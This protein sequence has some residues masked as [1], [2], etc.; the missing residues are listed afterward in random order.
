MKI[1]II[2]TI[3][4][5]TVNMSLVSMYS[6]L[7]NNLEHEIEFYLVF[8]EKF[9]KQ[10]LSTFDELKNFSNLK[11][12]NPVKTESKEILHATSYTDYTGERLYLFLLG[13]LLPN[14]DK[15]LYISI[16][17]SR[18][19]GD[20]G[21][22]SAGIVDNIKTI[23]TSLCGALGLIAVML[24]SSWK[25]AFIGILVLCIAFIP[26]VLIRKRIKEASNKNM[27]IGSKITTNINE[28]Y[29]G[30]K[31]MAAYELQDRQNEYF[32]SQLYLD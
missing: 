10:N 15:I 2:Y 13:K 12:I 24:Y 25:L 26:V 32:K 4:N 21:T 23:T 18:Y 20:P 1:N 7:T 6:V 11:N 8:D 22:A 27:V 5:E 28:T 9:N 17:I 16:V 31:V 30:N 19:M 3:T 29:S 14:M